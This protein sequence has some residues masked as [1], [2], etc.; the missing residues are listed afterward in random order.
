M[1]QK[2]FILTARTFWLVQALFGYLLTPLFS[3]TPCNNPI[4]L[5][6]VTVLNSTCGNTTGAVILNVAGGNNGLQFNWTPNVPGT[7]AIFDIPADAYRVNITRGNNGNCKFDTTIIVNNSDGPAT[8]VI[9]VRPANCFALNGQLTLAPNNLSY[10]WSNSE[11]G[12]VNDSLSS[13]CYTITATAA[14]GCYSVLQACVPNVNSLQVVAALLKPAKCGKANGKVGLTITGGTGNYDY[15]LGNGS[16]TLNNLAA[17]NYSCTI[18]DKVTGCKALTNFSVPAANPQATVKITTYNVRCPGN[19]DGFVVF[20][21]VPE[22]NFELPYTFTL[23]NASSGANASPGALPP[24]LYDLTIT[25]ADGCALPPSS[26]LITA[27][28]PFLLQS[29]QIPPTCTQA[30]QLLLSL[31]GGNGKFLVDW[32]DLPGT[33]NGKDRYNIGAGLYSAVIYDSLFCQYPLAS[34]FVPSNCNRA[35]TLF[36][37]LPVNTNDT[38]CLAL[39]T[40]ISQGAFALYGKSVSGNSTFG[41]WT[42]RPE[43]CLVYKA[44]SNPG[45]ALDTICVQAVT[46][47]NGLNKSWCVIVSLT[48]EK[49]QI[50]S[51]YFTVQLRASATACGNIPPNFN[52]PLVTRLYGSGL[53][54]SSG[55]FGTYTV[56]ARNACLT[57]KSIGQPGYFVDNI[58]INVYDPVLH[59]SKTICYIPSVLPLADCLPAVGLPDTLQLNVQNCND[60]AATC[61]PIPFSEV[62][63][64]AI[65]DNGAPYKSGFGNCNVE[66][67]TAYAGAQLPVGGP[68]TLLAWTVGTQS[69]SGV[70]ANATGL[71]ALMNQ[72]DPEGQW[73]LRNSNNLIVGGKSGK[74]YGT[75]KVAAVQG[76]NGTLFPLKESVARGTQMR[77]SAGFH[78][79]TFRQFNTGCIDTLHV[80]VRCS[81]CPPVHNYGPNTQ[82][83]LRWETQSCKTDTTFCTTIASI[84]LSRY[85]FRDNGQPF[86]K[87]TFC[88]ANVGLKLDTGYHALTIADILG[89]CQ[90]KINV[91]L[92][93]PAEVPVQSSSLALKEGEVKTICVDTSQLGGAIGTFVSNCPAKADG[94]VDVVLDAAK[95][96]LVLTG[97]DPGKDTLCL[98][99]C[100]KQGACMEFQYFLS[101]LEK[102]DS[103]YAA[104]DFFYGSKNK[105][106]EGGL[107]DNDFFGVFPSITL[108][109]QPQHGQLSFNAANGTFLYNPDANYC[110][111]DTFRY[112]I[113]STGSSTATA[114][115]SIRIVCDKILIFNGISPNGD[116]ENDVWHLPGIDQ[117][118]NNKVKVFNRWG[119]LVLDAEPYSNQTPWNGQWD[120]RDLPDGSYYYLIDLGDGSEVQSGY[121]QIRR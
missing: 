33:N 30:G 34:V 32:A 92:Q 75:L 94:N 121:L 79:V 25:D 63:T 110:G 98:K 43:G 68:F 109:A 28:P 67:K 100:N 101:I 93:C 96:C 58:Y 29:T 49:P 103:L 115:V 6:S 83:L 13:G 45:Y 4:V 61:L 10:L 3:Q 55:S 2:H 22:V 107:L 48:T 86:S 112:Q 91:L 99:I 24:G 102:A 41:S 89:A 27:P 19:N 64:Y 88:G 111:L 9:Q 53:A 113:Q 5:Q 74:T 120:G 8:Q 31:S 117:F 26:F 95:K 56:D 44:K 36:R 71:T 54:G 81:D 77:F 12:A 20:S 66:E 90:Y 82:D 70:F 39:P 80:N 42:L 104:P 23:K 78:R 116:G 69:Y 57:F 37:A 15:C 35:D 85:V 59:H 108:S 14:N 73:T 118:P 7:N 16:P 51:V 72:L 62:S 47:V 106:V 21:V 87:F 50:D 105:P 17:G 11:T 84:D 52:N 97:L 38:I 60:F 76:N 114:L 40:G 65:I 46:G 1:R 119:N 18:T